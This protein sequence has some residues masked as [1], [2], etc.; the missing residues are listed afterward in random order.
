MGNAHGDTSL[1]MR[2]FVWLTVLTVLE[3]GIVF[4]PIAKLVINMSLVILAVVKASMVAMYFMHLRLE[5]RALAWVALTP[6]ILGAFLVFMLLPDL[7][8]VSHHSPP[9][10]HPS[11]A[12]H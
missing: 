7:T 5:R 11:E 2:I 1:Y 8:A 9:T 12:S 10:A 6:L 3:I 4:M